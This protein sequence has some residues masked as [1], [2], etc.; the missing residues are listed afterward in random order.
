VSCAGKFTKC[1]EA[2][3]KLDKALE[4]KPR[5]II[6][7]FNPGSCT[8]NVEAIQGSTHQKLQTKAQ[9]GK[10]I[11]LAELTKGRVHWQSL[12]DAVLASFDKLW[13]SAG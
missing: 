5:M 4:I 7:L 2:R 12:G 1:E 8:G 13:K 10:M 9:I 6:N 11:I 3:R